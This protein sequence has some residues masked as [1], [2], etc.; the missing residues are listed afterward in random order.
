MKL[1]TNFDIST[2]NNLKEIFIKGQSLN[3]FDV[4]LVIDR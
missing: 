2:L 1:R 3:S 4:N